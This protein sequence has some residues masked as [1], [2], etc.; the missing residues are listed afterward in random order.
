MS[1]PPRDIDLSI[2]IHRFFTVDLYG[3][4]SFMSS[5]QDNRS[6][7]N[8]EEK[9]LWGMLTTIKSMISIQK[10]DLENRSEIL[11]DYVRFLVSNCVI[12]EIQKIQATVEYLEY[13]LIELGKYLFGAK[14]TAYT[15]SNKAGKSKKLDGAKP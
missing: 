5:G 4:K 11:A 9:S 10:H 13:K 1:G 7:L 14:K 15:S 12:G 2:L 3:Y 6:R 8:L